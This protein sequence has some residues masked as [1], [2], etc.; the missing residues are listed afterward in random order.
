MEKC[1]FTRRNYEIPFDMKIALN[2]GR[3]KLLEEAV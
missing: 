3:Q 2:N 1:F